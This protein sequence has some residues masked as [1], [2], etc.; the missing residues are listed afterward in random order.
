MQGVAAKE[1]GNLKDQSREERSSAG[2]GKLRRGK[3]KGRE[4][5]ETK[6]K[7]RVKG[8]VPYEWT[9]P[10]ADHHL[11]EIIPKVKLGSI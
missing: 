7:S 10:R 3:G 4:W 11:I 6:K 8:V 9:K 5:G 2:R 1:D